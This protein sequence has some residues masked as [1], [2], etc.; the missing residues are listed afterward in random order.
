MKKIIFLLT[1]VLSTTL[2]TIAQNFDYITWPYASNGEIE[3][4]ATEKVDSTL[5]KAVL[6]TRL[7]EWVASTWTNPTSVIQVND[8]EGGYLCIKGTSQAYMTYLNKRNPMGFINYT[9]NVW[10]KDGKYKYDIVNIRYTNAQ[11][12][13]DYSFKETVE[14]AKTKK[15]LKEV[16]EDYHYIVQLMI[17]SLKTKLSAPPASPSTDW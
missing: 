1:L 2:H 11:Y 5:T 16:C 9:F 17:S 7:M 6:Y 12:G 4:R 8:K 3:W 15:T 13:V 10:I 14:L